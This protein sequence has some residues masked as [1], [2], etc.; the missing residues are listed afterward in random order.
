[1]CENEAEVWHV[2]VLKMAAVELRNSPIPEGVTKKTRI[3]RGRQCCAFGCAN[4]ARDRQGNPT[5]IHH[6]RFP[7]KPP[8]KDI[9]CSKICRK[10]GRD[11]FK[12]TKST[13]ICHKHF[14]KEDIT[15]SLGAK[16][17]KLKPGAVPKPVLSGGKSVGP[18]KPRERIQTEAIP[19]AVRRVAF[20]HSTD[21]KI[22]VRDASVQTDIHHI[23]PH[24]THIEDHSYS[25]IKPSYLDTVDLCKEYILFLEKKLSE[26]TKEI[27]MLKCKLK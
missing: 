21:R 4:T 6:F 20:D 7:L 25:F 10:D 24:Q 26:S 8:M 14:K 12:V 3:S 1:M 9:W 15:V 11:S 19:K 17:W 13:V 5:G 16:I 2:I 22:S 23:I 18:E 27:Q